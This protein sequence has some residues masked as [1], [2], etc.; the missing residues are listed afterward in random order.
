MNARRKI[1]NGL[2]GDNGRSSVNNACT[3]RTPGRSQAAP[4][5]NTSGGKAKS[6]GVSAPNNAV[7]KPNQSR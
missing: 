4:I 6:V 7:N 1:M 3:G 2:S 5:K